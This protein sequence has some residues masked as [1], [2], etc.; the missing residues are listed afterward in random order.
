MPLNSRIPLIA[1]ELD[2]KTEAAVIEVAERIAADAKSRVPVATGALRDAIHV[3]TSGD[4]VRVVAGDS[5]AFYGHI[6]ENGSTKTPARP[7]LVPALEA[8]RPVLELLVGEKLR[9]L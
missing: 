8:V 7:F 9:S 3:D 1:A 6:V 2:A 5:T 4:G